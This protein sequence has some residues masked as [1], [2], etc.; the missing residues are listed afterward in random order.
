MNICYCVPNG[1]VTPPVLHEFVGLHCSQP[2]DMFQYVYLSGCVSRLN[3]DKF[4]CSQG[5]CYNYVILPEIDTEV[6]VI[7]I[8]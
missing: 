5:V 3:I 8:F 1:L 4:W 2:L 7:N 6:L